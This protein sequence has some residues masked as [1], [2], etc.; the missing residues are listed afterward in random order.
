MRRRILL[1]SIS[2][3]K[4]VD[5]GL[6]SGLL[7]AKCDIG[8][9]NEYDVVN[10]FQ[11]GDI[12]IEQDAYFCEICDPNKTEFICEECYNTCHKNIT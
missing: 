7:W 11:Y 12:A 3:N 4:F 6:P 1:N 2:T 8:A 9:E 10:Y 5:F